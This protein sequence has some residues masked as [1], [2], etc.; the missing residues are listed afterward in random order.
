MFHSEVYG[1]TRRKT[2]GKSMTTLY[3]NSNLEFQNYI[4]FS[5]LTV[6]FDPRLFLKFPFSTDSY[7]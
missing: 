7:H 6:Y 5:K 1:F 3:L 2:R 4:A